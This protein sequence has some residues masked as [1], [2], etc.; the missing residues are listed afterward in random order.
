[1]KRSTTIAFV[2][3]VHYV[4]RH[5]HDWRAP[6]SLAVVFAMLVLLGIPALRAQQPRASE[7]QVKATYIYNFARFVAWPA[8]SAAAKS[9]EFA[10]CVLGRDPFGSALDSVVAGEIMDGKA[11]SVKRV[12][13]PRDAISCRVLFISSSEDSRLKEILAALDKACV[14]TVSDM[15]QFS[16]RGGMIQFVQESN[17][18][19]FEVNL[20]SAENAGLS[21]SSELLKVAITVRRNSQPG[22]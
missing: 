9:D 21:L 19:R 12:S 1:M 16:Q 18:I 13:K 22:D 20:A 11:V 7:Y 15:P 4:W 5:S 17:K 2:R 3:H 6:Q 10:L 8:T 14:L